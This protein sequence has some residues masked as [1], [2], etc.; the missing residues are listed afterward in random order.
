MR[1]VAALYVSRGD[2]RGQSDR[3]ICRVQAEFRQGRLRLLGDLDR[4][5]QVTGLAIAPTE[6]DHRFDLREADSGSHRLLQR[7]DGVLV[8]TAALQRAAEQ[9][10][11]AGGDLRRRDH[12]DLLQDTTGLPLDLLGFTVLQGQLGEVQAEPEFL[13]PDARRAVQQFVDR[14]LQSFGEFGEQCRRRT[15]I[16]ALDPR[17][18]CS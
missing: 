9:E 6:C 4:Q 16:A 5:R 10:P 7:L 17:H 12:V 14:H 3:F 1:E 11:T 2:R 13:Q 8:T 18:V 15:S